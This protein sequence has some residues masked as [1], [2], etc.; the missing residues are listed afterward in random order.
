MSITLQ[1]NRR[2]YL[3]DPLPLT[4][5]LFYYFV[6]RTI[7]W[8]TK[9]ARLVPNY[10]EVQDSFDQVVP[11]AAGF[12]DKFL[13]IIQDRCNKSGLGINLTPVR[14]DRKSDRIVMAGELQFGSAWKGKRS[15]SLQAYADRMG[16]MLQVGWQLNSNEV[17]MSRVLTGYT[18]G[19]ATM[20]ARH[21]ERQTQI[22]N[23]PNTM[24]MLNGIVQ[25]FHQTVFLPTLQ[26]LINAIGPQQPQSGFLGTS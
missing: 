6:D 19:G 24:R 11:G 4:C 16:Q 17:E 10:Q 20:Q 14:L 7:R 1:V 18:A 2:V 22:H 8:L 21:R 25:G 23:D 26:D 13:G 9:G 5:D 15:Y 12:S 3:A